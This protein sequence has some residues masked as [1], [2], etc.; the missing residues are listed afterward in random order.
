MNFYEAF[1][2]ELDKLGARMVTKPLPR[3]R[4]SFFLKSDPSGKR[5]FKYLQGKQ[6]GLIQ[7]KIQVK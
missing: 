6:K 5:Y 2:D 3:K 7:R 1:V 4:E